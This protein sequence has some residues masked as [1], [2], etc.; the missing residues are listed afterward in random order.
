[1]MGILFWSLLLLGPV[2][3]C[4]Q[5]GATG[6][7]WVCGGFLKRGL[8]PVCRPQCALGPPVCGRDW[9]AHVD[10]RLHTTNG[11]TSR[12]SA[13]ADSTV[14]MVGKETP[15]WLSFVSLA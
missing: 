8:S 13:N 3:Q 1:M 2:P 14:S 9:L 5:G 15:Y 6:R 12:S 10:M 4:A 7:K 11:E